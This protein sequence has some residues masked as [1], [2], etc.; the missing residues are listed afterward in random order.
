MRPPRHRLAVAAPERAAAETAAL[1]GLA[2]QSEAR[3][4]DIDRGDWA[5]RD[6]ASLHRADPDRLAAWLR[7]PASAVP[8]G[9]AMDGVAR[10][11]AGWLRQIETIDDTLLAIAHAAVIRAAIAVA[12]EIPVGRTLAIDIAPLSQTI[13]SFNRRWRLQALHA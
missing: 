3:L 13:L 4:A 5:G 10:R 7:D 6:L 1:G 8:G 9:E 11:V 2:A 12:I